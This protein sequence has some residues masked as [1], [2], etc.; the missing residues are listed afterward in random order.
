VTVPDPPI[1]PRAGNP[2]DD[3]ISAD[4][5]RISG[6][7]GWL[8]WYAQREGQPRRTSGHPGSVVIHP[9]WEEFAVYTDVRLEGGWLMTGPFE[10]IAIDTLTTPVL[11]QARKLLLLRAWDH[12]V[13][14]P[15][16]RD[17]EVRDDVL[18]YFGGDIG[19]EIAA[20][21]GLALARRFR[22]GGRVRLGLPGDPLGHP[23]EILH[24]APALEPP[25][26]RAMIAALADPVTLT[27]AAELLSVYPEMDS[28]DAVALVRGARQ[29]VDGLW[30]ADADP[31]LAWI[32]LI[33]ALEAVA[34]RFDDKRQETAIQQLKR[35]RKGLYRDLSARSPEVLETVAEEFARLYNVER[36]VWSFVRRFDPGPPAVRPQGM[37]WRFDW[38]R[39]GEALAIIYQHRSRDLHDG[40]AFPWPLCEPPHRT[41]DGLPAERFPALGVRGRGGQWSAEILPMY[42]HVFAH[43]VGGALRAWWASL[44]PASTDQNGAQ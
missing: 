28:R 36:K 11:G 20:L 24:H 41:E 15:P 29:Y 19:D 17:A 40:I 6:P 31:R 10:F 35:H 38:S 5:E 32:K 16:T 3:D 22:S 43:L 33:G 4:S 1:E 42:L 30:L 39:L 37:G 26:R 14:G 9:I 44:A 13:D 23:D 2:P 25:H 18:H 21:L 27:D 7:H 8:N 34:N 12:L